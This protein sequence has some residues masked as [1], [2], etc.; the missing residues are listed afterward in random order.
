MP[1]AVP[2]YRQPRPAEPV[3]TRH[4]SPAPHLITTTAMC[5]N[6]PEPQPAAICTTPPR[7]LNE[8]LGHGARAAQGRVVVQDDSNQVR[9]CSPRALFCTAEHDDSIKVIPMTTF[10][11]GQSSQGSPNIEEDPI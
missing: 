2:Q 3:V 6:P 10:T 7:S 8:E 9:R 11:P 1:A 4:S 5:H